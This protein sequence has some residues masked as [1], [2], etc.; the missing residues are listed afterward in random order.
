MSADE[1]APRDLRIPLDTST[2]AHRRQRDVYLKMGGAARVAIAF[3]LNEAVRNVAMAGIRQRHPD[4]T[5]EEVRLAWVRLTL[6]DGLCR[7]VWPHQPL[8]EP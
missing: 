6:G 1:R 2:E 3:Q 8:V 7:A 5:S 4:Y